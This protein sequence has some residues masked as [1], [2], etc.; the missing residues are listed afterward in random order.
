M[1]QDAVAWRGRGAAARWPKFRQIT[2]CFLQLKVPFF[3][4]VRL[5]LQI[6]QSPKKNIPKYYPELEISISRQLQ[7]T[8]IGGKIKFQAQDSFLEYFFF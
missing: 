5:V 7:Y 6:Y 1:L 8:V 4:K 2:Q 3:Q